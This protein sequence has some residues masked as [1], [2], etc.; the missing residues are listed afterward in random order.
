MTDKKPINGQTAEH[1]S[2]LGVGHARGQVGNLRYASEPL[3][4]AM[5]L[6]AGGLFFQDGAE[7]QVGASADSDGLAVIFAS[8][9]F[10]LDDVRAGRQL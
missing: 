7:G 6:L 3:R 8:R 1:S 5:P 10:D 9:F 2:G 4:Y